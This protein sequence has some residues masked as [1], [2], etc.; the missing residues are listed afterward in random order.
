MDIRQMKYFIAVADEMSFTKAAEKLFIAQP[1]LSRAIQNLEEEL[2]VSLLVRNTR[3]IELTE[4]GKYFYENSKKIV[5]SEMHL[6]KMT[7][8]IGGANNTLRIGFIGSAMYSELAECIKYY[9]LKYPDISIHVEAMNT[10]QQIEELKNGKIDIGVGGLKIIDHEIERIILK[11]EKLYVALYK[12]HPLLQLKVNQSLSLEDIVNEPMILFP[13]TPQP[14]FL[15]I[16]LEIFEVKM[17]SP[18]NLFEPVRDIQSAL[19]LVLAGFGITIVNEGVVN[20]Y[21]KDLVFLPLSEEFA[22]SPIILRYR[23]KENYTVVDNFVNVAKKIFNHK[24][25]S[26]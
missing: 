3:S 25:K 13:D 22:F 9:R 4:A 2:E 17:M 15:L 21:S 8:Q 10:L 23:K 12:E 18:S 24:L 6:K 19:G 1:P 16:I 14:N 7:Q 5:Q 11:E 20:L 26:T